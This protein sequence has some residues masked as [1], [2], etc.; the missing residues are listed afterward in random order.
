MDLSIKQLMFFD[1]MMDKQNTSKAAAQLGITQAGASALL[2]KLRIRFGDDLFIRTNNGM[3]PTEKAVYLHGKLK[4]NLDGIIHTI[5]DAQRFDTN[6]PFHFTIACNDYFGEVGLT[7]VQDVIHSRNEDIS[8]SVVNLPTSLAKLPG[9]RSDLLSALRDGSIDL[10]IHTDKTLA[11]ANEQMKSQR[12]LS[13]SWDAIA[14][15]DTDLTEAHTKQIAATYKK[16]KGNIPVQC[17]TEDKNGSKTN[18]SSNTEVTSFT[19]LPSLIQDSDY[20]SV[21]PKRLGLIWTEFYDINLLPIGKA[22]PNLNCYQI[23]HERFHNSES[24][25]WL[26]KSI[27]NVCSHV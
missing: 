3:V 2:K 8:L 11:Q 1:I 25:K 18:I 23:W 7:R 24:N 20:I 14:G 27:Y 21:V 9:Y 4:P 22:I 17:I 12:I 15:E 10:L 5:Q 13:D 6:A 26:R 19:V 16:L